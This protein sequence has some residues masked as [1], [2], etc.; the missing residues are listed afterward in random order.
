MGFQ[1]EHIKPG[2]GSLMSSYGF[3]SLVCVGGQ[4]RNRATTRASVVI[5]NHANKLS[6]RFQ[7]L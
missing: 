3:W 1:E 7:G 6:G 2:A 4:D 5:T